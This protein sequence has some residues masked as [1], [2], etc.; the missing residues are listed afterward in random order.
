MEE[1]LILGPGWIESLESGAAVPQID[2]LLAMADAAGVKLASLVEGI[3][4]DSAAPVG[5]NLS[6]ESRR[7]AIA[8]HFPYGDYDATYE[9]AGVR[10]ADVELVLRELRNGLTVREGKADAVKNAFRT[11]VARMPEANP[12]DL[13]WFLLYR[14]Y[15]DP[16]NHPATEAR[17]NLDQSWK[18]TSGWALERVLVEHYKGAFA[19][20]GIR[21]FVGS[22]AEKR[23]LLP[24]NL[25]R[26]LEQAKVDV[27]L[28][29]DD[30]GTE[31]FFGVVNVKASFA[32]RRTDDVPLSEAL[33][34]NGYTSIFW[35]MDCKSSPAERPV[36]RGELGRA[37]DEKDDSRSAKRRDFEVEGSFSACFS[38][39]RRTEPTPPE[40]KTAAARVF[41]VNFEDPN[42]AF[43]SFVA[44]EWKRFK[45]RRA[46]EA[47][48]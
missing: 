9:L 4:V 36:N 7:S 41:V 12:S 43:T 16:F 18:R 24:N 21:I 17:R 13:W 27:L 34:A 15:I 20:R 45:Q 48:R 33:L 46:G 11:A 40:Q 39:N 14:A 28:T 2:L 26:R 47:S 32:E 37:F 22:L 42:D 10:L 30:E 44:A 5:R 25:A 19:A 8:L 6:A 3:E 1:K 38:Y 35:T 23:Q 29:A 31:R